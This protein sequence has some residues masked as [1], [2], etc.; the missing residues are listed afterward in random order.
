MSSRATAII[1]GLVASA[2]TVG[3]S[4]YT[5]DNSGQSSGT[6]VG[7]ANGVQLSLRTAR[8]A[9]VRVLASDPMLGL[10]VGDRITEADG[11]PINMPEE[12]FER[13]RLSG[14]RPISLTLERDGQ[15]ITVQIFGRNF[16][17]LM[18]PRPPALPSD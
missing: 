9:G 7:N 1:G 3:C 17:T 16:A 14:S 4:N 12:L 13:M 15:P 2:V 11:N 8:D 5:D 6:Y 10:E 18:P